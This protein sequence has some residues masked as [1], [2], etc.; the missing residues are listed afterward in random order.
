MKRVMI[1]VLPTDWS[2][3]NTNLYLARAETGAIFSDLQQKST[4]LVQLHEISAGC[5]QRREGD[6]GRDL[7][8]LGFSGFAFDACLPAC[9]PALF[10][11][12]CIEVI[13]WRCV[14]VRI[15]CT[16][17]RAL[18]LALAPLE[19]PGLVFSAFI[20]WITKEPA[21]LTMY[22]VFSTFSV[23]LYIP[24]RLLSFPSQG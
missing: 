21:S 22:T 15:S 3:K 7:G 1:L 23:F 10:I 20:I 5:I 14:Y 2:P 4:V 8:G 12:L 16:C 6:G 19:D 13:L 24:L 11:Y 18:A 9:L 17:V